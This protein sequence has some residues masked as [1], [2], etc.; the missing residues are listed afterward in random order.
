MNQNGR[1]FH[2]GLARPIDQARANKRLIGGQPDTAREYKKG[3]GFTGHPP[4]LFVLETSGAGMASHSATWRKRRMKLSIAILVGAVTI[5]AQD[6]TGTQQKHLSIP[7]VGKPRP[8]AAS[9]LEID[10]GISYPSVVHLKGNVE[11]RMPVCVVTG[12]ERTHQCAG[13]IVVS[14][15]EA[16]IHEDTGQVEAKGEIRVTPR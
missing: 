3:D 10:R 9:A 2:G 6:Q 15:T 11:I 12:P 4:I 8:F 13:E 1:L 16:D 7:I 14:A 5:S